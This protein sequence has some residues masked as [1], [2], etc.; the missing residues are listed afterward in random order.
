MIIK[1]HVLVLILGLRVLLAELQNTH[2]HTD[3][4]SKSSTRT[5]TRTCGDV[6]I[7]KRGSL[8][9]AVVARARRRPRP[10]VGRLV[11][12]GDKLRPVPPLRD[13]LV[14]VLIH[15]SAAAAAAAGRADD[16]CPDLRDRLGDRDEGLARGFHLRELC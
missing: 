6:T 15:A 10:R 7:H 2:G 13:V 14:P 12:D 5:R 16:G 9:G 3:T 11:G 8:G 4:P 1:A